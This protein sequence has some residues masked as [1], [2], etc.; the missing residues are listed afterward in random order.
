MKLEIRRCKIS[1]RR[2]QCAL[3]RSLAR[4][5]TE[6][7]LTKVDTRQV[8]T[9]K[10]EIRAFIVARNES[11]R[12]PYILQYYT[13][14]GVDRIFVIDNNSSD[15]TS[16]IVLSY[17]NTHLFFTKDHF[18]SR[19]AYWIDYLLR[20]YGQDHWCVIIDADEILAYPFFETFTIRGLC[21]FLEEENTN[22]M[23]CF[24]LDMYPQTPLNQ[25]KYQSGSD[26]LLT[27]SWFDANSY[28]QRNP[29]PLY[30]AEHNII[31]DGPAQSYGGMRK[32]VFGIDPCVSK[33]P[34]VKFKKSMFLSTG[35]HWI[36]GARVSDI[37]GALLHFKFLGDFVG[38][39]TAAAAEGQYWNNSSEYKAYLSVIRKNPELILHSTASVKF[40]GSQQLIALGIMKTSS[41]FG[42]YATTIS[43]TASPTSTLP[44][45]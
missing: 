3:R 29:G 12:L 39:V 13:A 36:E 27:A 1:L 24:L 40:G 8:P 9:H 25:T 23:G 44:A 38:N 5:R 41:R 14:Q 4:R 19:K 32:R 15:D 16:K 31:H 37:R 20:R 26:P 10:H 30:I 35:L 21:D 42:H 22:A 34:L 6:H 43:P 18:S 2:A 7:K 28:A 33:F 11:L 45:A 17:Q